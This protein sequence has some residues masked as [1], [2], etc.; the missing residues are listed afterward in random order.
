MRLSQ[1]E[2]T[3]RI[4]LWKARKFPSPEFLDSNNNAL[5]ILIVH[6]ELSRIYLRNR[7][8]YLLRSASEYIPPAS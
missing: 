4:K 5:T 2:D 3:E 7:R 8:Y 6:R 1:T